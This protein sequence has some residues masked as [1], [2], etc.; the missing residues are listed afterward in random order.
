MGKRR[1]VVTGLGMV[2]PLGLDVHQTWV[3]LLRGQSGI[4]RLPQFDSEAFSTKIG[5][6]VKNFDPSGAISAKDLKKLDL[7]IQYGAVAAKQ[8][9]DDAGLFAAPEK[10]D[11]TRVGVLIGSGI[12]G[13]PLIE[14]TEVT[15]L[16]S[17]PRKISPFFIPGT[18]INTVSGY[19]AMQHGLFGPNFSIVSACATGG[20]SIGQAMRMIQY[21]DADVMIA[22]GTEMSTCA[23]GIGGFA[24]CRTLSQ[25]NDAPA[26]ASRPWDKDRDGFVLSE[27]AGIVVLES[28][29]HAKARGANIYAE[30]SGFG[31][32]GDAYHLTT[33]HPEA[34]GQTLAIEHA[35]KDAGLNPEQIQ[36]IN[37]HAT[38][39]PVGDNYEV[40]AIKR[41]FGEH[42]YR[43]AI[44]STKSMTGH[45]LGAA[46]AIE[47]IFCILAIQDQVMPPTINLDHPSA[48]CDLDFIPHQA[49]PAMVQAAL[50]NSF[51]FAGANSA[52]IF[53]KLKS[54]NAA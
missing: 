20:H 34:R 10:I 14:K 27:G 3:A 52:L 13:L 21:G 50:S 35:L 48:D 19:V 39:T 38:S 16:E 1:V 15:L 22:G 49:R 54:N 40:M 11:G 7:F 43:L 29:E 26:R 30:L 37:A 44:S 47:A 12:G 33:P 25:R 24:A 17:G 32:S 18:I 23:L 28:Y 5:G 42:A 31:M 2:T 9:I 41:A 36:Y 8:A 51:G 4:Q 46:G 53:Q 45:L 6:A